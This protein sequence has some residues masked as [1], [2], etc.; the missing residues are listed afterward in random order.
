MPKGCI[1]AHK[2]PAI[3]VEND[4]S[5]TLLKLSGIAQS[6]TFNYLVSALTARV[7]LAQSYEVGLIKSIPMPKDS[8]IKN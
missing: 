1:F 8:G 4:V 2:G 3:F 6:I 5:A 7:T